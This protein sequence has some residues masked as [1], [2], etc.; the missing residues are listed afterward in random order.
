MASFGFGDRDKFARA[1]SFFLN[2]RSIS[3]PGNNGG[4]TFTHIDPA[5]KADGQSVQEV[6]TTTTTTATVLSH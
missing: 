2:S 6:A 3:W 1:A 4:Q 5:A